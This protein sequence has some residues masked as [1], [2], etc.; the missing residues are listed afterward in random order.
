[1]VSGVTKQVLALGLNNLTEKKELRASKTAE[2]TQIKEDLKEQIA[3]KAN[4]LRVWKNGRI[5]FGSGELKTIS[6]NTLTITKEDKTYTV[7]VDD[8]TQLRRKFWGKSEL[9]EFSVGDKLNVVGVWEDEQKTT[10]RAKFIRNIS[11][12]KR[13]GV[14]IGV[15]KNKTASG[16]TLETTARGEQVVT[17]GSDTEYVNRKMIK[18]NLSDIIDGHR[19]KVRGLWDSN[20]STITEV[21]QI[22]D[23]S[24]PVVVSASV[25]S[26]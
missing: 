11:I 19:V 20:L 7:L 9:S 23:F 22:K 25:K 4:W 18:I 14:F 17:V 10:I 21:S 8:K 15:V 1:M 12:Q 6:G 2:V 16:F 5:A 3:T 13:H 24:L 26:E